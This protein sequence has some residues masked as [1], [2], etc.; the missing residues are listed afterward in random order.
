MNS[1]DEEDDKITVLFP[2]GTEDEGTDSEDR[3]GADLIEADDDDDTADKKLRDNV[4]ELDFEG[5]ASPSEQKNV[6][7]RSEKDRAKFEV[8]ETMIADGM[9]MVTLDTRVDGVKVPPKFQGLSELRLNFSY[10][11]QIEDFDFDGRG[12][13]ASLSFQGTR[14]FCDIPWEAVFMVYS[15]ESGEFAVFEPEDS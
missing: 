10:L 14:H 8:F 6:E 13:R 3:S 9:V 1:R 5:G 15:H 2:G 11:F 7:P 4:V 12:V